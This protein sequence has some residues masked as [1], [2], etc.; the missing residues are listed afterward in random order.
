MLSACSSSEN[1]PSANQP[2]SL[3][4]TPPPTAMLDANY[5][6]MPGSSDLDGDPLTFS[7][8]NMPSWASFD[9]TSGALT[10][11]PL[12]QHIGTY[13]NISISVSDGKASTEIPAF[14]IEVVATATGSISL[15][16]TPP[17]QSADGTPLIDLAS[18]RIHWGTQSG[19]YPNLLQVDSPGVSSF[20]IDGLAAGNYFFAV[21]AVD[22]SD[23]ESQVSNEASGTVP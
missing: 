5:S 14:A 12:I 4:G 21:S 19:I 15:S 6:F 13:A 22:T 9:N 20:V 16:W 10:G 1:L 17:M 18:Y 7:I 23:N 11:M 2:P 3:S 8:T